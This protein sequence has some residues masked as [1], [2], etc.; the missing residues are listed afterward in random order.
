[1]VW[2]FLGWAWSVVRVRV[3]GVG[4]TDVLVDLRLGLRLVR[5]LWWGVANVRMPVVRNWRA[6]MHVMDNWGVRM[7]VVGSRGVRIRG[8]RVRLRLRIWDRLHVVRVSWRGRV[9][10]HHGWRSWWRQGSVVARSGRLRATRLTLIWVISRAMGDKHS[11]G[12]DLGGSLGVGI[13]GLRVMEPNTRDVLSPIRRLGSHESPRLSG[14]MGRM[15]FEYVHIKPLSMMRLS[16]RPADGG[17]YLLQAVDWDRIF[18]SCGESEMEVTVRRPPVTLRPHD[19]HRCPGF[20]H[21]EFRRIQWPSAEEG[22]R[23]PAFGPR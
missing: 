3:L 12:A 14:R 4:R 1:M 16:Q 8:M 13:G 17:G 15:G 2:Q 10:D 19:P 21:R 9:P 11:L 6:R 20:K 7:H 18:H 22:R 23:Q 5:R